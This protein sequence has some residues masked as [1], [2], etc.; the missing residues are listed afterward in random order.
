MRRMTSEE[1]LLALYQG[2]WASICTVDHDRKPYAIEATYFL[3]VKDR[4][5]FMINPKGTTI[6]NIR[7][8]PNVLLK[9]TQASKDLAYWLGVSFRGTGRVVT[10]KN[11]MRQGWEKLGKVMSTDYSR[12]AEKFCN[13]DKASPFLEIQ[14]EQMTGQCS[15]G[16]NEDID[17]NLFS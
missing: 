13:S 10:D 6:K 5:G 7:T 15:H 4:I 14:M 2:T 1:S 3:S 12:A 8:N 17:Y 9:I 16:K 11:Q